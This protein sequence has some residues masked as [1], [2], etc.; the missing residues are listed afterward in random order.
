[1]QDHTELAVNST[2]RLH[3]PQLEK[4]QEDMIFFATYFQRTL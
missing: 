1:M 4:A 3:L 2:G